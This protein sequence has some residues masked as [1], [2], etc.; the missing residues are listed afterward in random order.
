MLETDKTLPSDKRLRLALIMIVDGVLIAHKQ[1]AKPTLHYVRMVDNLDAFLKFPWGRESFLKT[2]TCM[3]PPTDAADPVG[4]LA[5]VL[6]QTTYRLTGFALALQ[7]VAM[8]EIPLL[9]TKIPAP[10]YNLTLLDL[11]EGHL[12]PH[13]SIHLEDFLTVEADTQETTSVHPCLDDHNPAYYN[14]GSTPQAQP[15]PTKVSSQDN[16]P[17]SPSGETISPFVSQYN[18][19]RFSANRG[20]ITTDE[21]DLIINSVIKSTEQA[22]PSLNP[23]SP[24]NNSTHHY[25]PKTKT[26]PQTSTPP[27]PLKTP[28]SKTPLTSTIKQQ[29]TNHDQPTKDIEICSAPPRLYPVN[30]SPKQIASI[31]T[32]ISHVRKPVPIQTPRQLGFVAHATT[33]NDFASQATSKTTSKTST[34][35]Q[36]S[37]NTKDYNVLERFRLSNSTCLQEHSD[38]LL[39]ATSALVYVSDSSPSKKLPA[40]V[41]SGPEEYI[42]KLLLSSPPVPATMLFA[43]IDPQLWEDFH[44][45]LQHNQDMKAK[46]ALQPVLEMLPFIISKLTTNTPSQFEGDRPFTWQRRKEI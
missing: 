17:H 45:T 19:Q 14:A 3:K 26:M 11:D 29:D 18:A 44:N 12:P 34:S 1:V 4:A 42:A 32:R 10:Y 31:P 36:V 24:H 25:S 5:Q 28:K 35:D 23:M 27:S 38:P 13:G 9:A 41:P 30:L 20:D 16:S 6:Q 15:Q 33:V 43:P 39:E 7:L 2:I 40:H 37:T 46:T 8:K 22:H 21:A